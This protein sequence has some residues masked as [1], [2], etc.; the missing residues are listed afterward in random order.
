MGERNI[1][2]GQQLE[3]PNQLPIIKPDVI[4]NEIKNRGEALKQ[5][6]SLSADIDAFLGSRSDIKIKNY[7]RTLNENSSMK[8]IHAALGKT[9][10]E[11]MVSFYLAKGI[12]K[13]ALK[14]IVITLGDGKEQRV[15][16]IKADGTVEDD[17][18]KLIGLLTGGK[19]DYNGSN[20]KL[21]DT[22]DGILEKIT[23]QGWGI[24]NTRN[25]CNG[26]LTDE[27]RRYLLAMPAPIST[28]TVTAKPDPSRQYYV[29][30]RFTSGSVTN[31]MFCGGS[32]ITQ[33]NHGP[34]EGPG[35]RDLT[36]RVAAGG[37][38]FLGAANGSVVK[39]MVCP[40]CIPGLD[41]GG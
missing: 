36:V 12:S 20:P 28:T 3:N 23:S 5:A 13:E 38:G 2:Q 39:S 34:K 18:Q 37:I 24:A 21:T 17:P 9:L 30:D 7:L 32:A 41:G 16:L 8:D 31:T 11:T 6:K 40:P 26:Q 35:S 14:D 29:M 4:R 25:S 15:S 10:A 19:F 33:T 22:K 1:Q 27:I